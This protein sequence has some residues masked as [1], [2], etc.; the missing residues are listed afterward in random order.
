MG[1]RGR[2]STAELTVVSSEAIQKEIVSAIERP[3]APPELTAEQESI[4]DEIVDELAADYFTTETFPLLAQYCRHVTRARRYAQL[5][6]S[7]EKKK[8]FDEKDIKAYRDLSRSEEEQTRAISSLATKMRLSQQ[9]TYDRQKAKGKS[10][11]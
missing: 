10:R 1:K 8:K 3:Q 4:W 6:E 2:K 9:S 7:M 11:F 5:L